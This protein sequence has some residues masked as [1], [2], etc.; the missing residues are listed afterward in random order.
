MSCCESFS[1]IFAGYSSPVHKTKQGISWMASGKVKMNLRM[2]PK[3]V[4]YKTIPQK[5]SNCWHSV[6]LNTYTHTHTHMYTHTHT[7]IDPYTHKHTSI[8]KYTLS[9]THAHTH[10]HA[11]THKI[12]RAV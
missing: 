9:H 5:V 7:H 6:T 12:E 1:S 3:L 2:V 8:H 10:T 11:P 4:A